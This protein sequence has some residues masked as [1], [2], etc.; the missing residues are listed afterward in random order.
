[1]PPRLL[2]FGW[3]AAFCLP[4]SA[5][6]SRSG[7]ALEAIYRIPID[8][9][10][11]LV[12]TGPR[13]TSFIVNSLRLAEL[14][15]Y[16]GENV[17]SEQWLSAAEGRCRETGWK[18]GAL[19][20]HRLR[21]IEEE[22]G[23]KNYAAALGHYSSAASIAEQQEW[24][25][26]SH[27]MYTLLLN[28]CFYTGDFVRAMQIASKGL[29]LAETAG[30]DGRIAGYDNIVGFI[31]LRQQNSAAARQFYSL[32]LASA[33]RRRDTLLMA[34]AQNCLAEVCLAEK[35]YDRALA[36][37]GN[38]RAIYRDLA[39]G[40]RLNKMDRIPYTLFKTAYAYG[41]RG[42]PVRALAFAR[43]ALSY[44]TT[45]S[46]NRYDVAAY[47]LYTGSLYLELAQPRQAM[48]LLR[49]G[50]AISREIHHQ[51]D[52]RDAYLYLHRLFAQVKRFDSAY[53]YYLLYDRLKDS[54]GNEHTTRQIEQIGNQYHLEKKDRQ[55]ELLSQQK[56]W[57][58]ATLDRQL[59]IRNLSLGFLVLGLVIAGLVL[60]RRELKNKQKIQAAINHEQ[61]E[62][63]HLTAAIQD[64]ERKR[65]AQDLHDG[66][67]TL[68]SAARL[69]LSA[70]PADGNSIV[71]ATQSLLDD[72]IGEL[73]NIAHN[74]MPASLLRLGLVK[75]LQSLFDQLS[76][77]GRL[78]ISFIA[79]GFEERLQEEKEI[80]VY[81]MI[82][83]LVNNAVKHSGASLATVQLLR[84]PGE[85]NI[86]VEDKG[87]GFDVS[88]TGDRGIGLRNI[89][90]RV[91]YLRGSLH[92][93][94]APGTGTTVIIDLPDNAK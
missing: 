5:Q 69:K 76:A 39:A 64:A 74:I 51:E 68:L 46:C 79:F 37:L 10:D 1:M 23:R 44:V 28:L 36:Y 27:E 77:D 73:Q 42:D 89:A 13:D 2:F 85:I 81:R 84:R 58:E 50:M 9:L 62:L 49:A 55:I 53:F 40:K 86:V 30:D 43:Q 80:A 59:L 56:K 26:E 93:D 16:A 11:R 21:G 63:F 31:Y 12:Q 52:L 47:Y 71:A 25:P 32:Y 17:R 45:V 90:S 70:L 87:C 61:H 92:I 91:T 88:R 15:F 33:T 14:C 38:A 20:I 82:L 67:G 48:P 41:S 19:L 7:E 34:D 94:S 4:S 57:Q 65:M 60:N 66:M 8:S 75:A 78:Q 72:A 83:E 24:Y 29:R 3:F 35:D 22:T 18:R 6:D 54:I